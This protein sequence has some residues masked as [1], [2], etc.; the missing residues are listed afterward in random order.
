MAMVIANVL[1]ISEPAISDGFRSLGREDNMERVAA[2]AFCGVFQLKNFHTSTYKYMLYI[3]TH[4]IFDT[5]YD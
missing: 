5:N 1:V 2:V 3:H 4:T